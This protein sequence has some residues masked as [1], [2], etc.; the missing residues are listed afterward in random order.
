MQK[1][2]HYMF[3]N[4]HMRLSAVTLHTRLGRAYPRFRRKQVFFAVLKEYI[5]EYQQL[6]LSKEHKRNSLQLCKGVIRAM[7][8]N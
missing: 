7:S 2:K 1:V 3:N 4:I 5:H 6:K 8:Q